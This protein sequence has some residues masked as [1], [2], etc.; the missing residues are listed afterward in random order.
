MV[1]RLEWVKAGYVDV[2]SLTALP[3]PPSYPNL[4]LKECH[5]R[6]VDRPISAY[7]VSPGS[8]IMYVDIPGRVGTAIIGPGIMASPSNVRGAIV[9][10]DG[11]RDAVVGPMGANTVARTIPFKNHSRRKKARRDSAYLRCSQSARIARRRW[12]K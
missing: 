11:C 1:W 5:R 12:Y 10:V 8:D 9:W 6:V 3:T 7:Q 4:T 2:T